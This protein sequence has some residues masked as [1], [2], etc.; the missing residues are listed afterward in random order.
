M[1]ADA[2][3]KKGASARAAVAKAAEKAPAD[4]KARYEDVLL[5]M[6]AGSD[7]TSVQ[8]GQ[9]RFEILDATFVQELDRDGKAQLRLK[10]VFDGAAIGDDAV[11]VTISKST[12]ILTKEKFSLLVLGSKGEAFSRKFDPMTPKSF[13][14]GAIVPPRWPPGS[15]A[16]LVFELDIGGKK[17]SLRTKPATIE[18]KE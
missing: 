11:T 10:A 17:V 7:Q 9:F 13:E 3:V 5:R 15:R 1:A 2:L 4:R 6:D 14:Y 16:L 8:V 18:K 12:L